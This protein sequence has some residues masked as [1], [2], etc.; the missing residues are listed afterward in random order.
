MLKV[1]P[2][3]FWR[4][5]EHEFPILASAAQDILSIPATGAGVE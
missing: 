4:D 5:H 3:N 2:L 1:H